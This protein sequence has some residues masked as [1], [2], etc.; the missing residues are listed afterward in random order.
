MAQ[1]EAVSK[2]DNEKGMHEMGRTNNW[3]KAETRRLIIIIYEIFYL[4]FKILY[5]YAF[6]CAIY[7]VTK[8]RVA[9]YGA[10]L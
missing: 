1:T 3:N 5:A 8:M 6:C 9:N 4:I 7:S 10:G 2:C